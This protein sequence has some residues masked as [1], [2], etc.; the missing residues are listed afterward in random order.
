M[1][2]LAASEVA[3]SKA[4]TESTNSKSAT[5]WFRWESYLRQIDID[6]IFLSSFSREDRW[7]VLVGFC[8]A[9][10]DGRF[11]PGKRK[12]M[13]QGTIQDSLSAVAQAFRIHRGDDPRVDNQG[14]TALILLR[15][16]K[17]LKSDDPPPK[18][19]APATP[20]LIRLLA[21]SDESVPLDH[22]IGKL[23]CGSYFY[24]MRS[25]EYLKV[26]GPRK[27]KILLVEDIQF[28]VANREIHHSSPEIFDSDTVTLTFKD[29]KNGELMQRRTAWR[30]TDPI[31]SPVKAWASIVTRILSYQGCSKKTSVNT[32]LVNG[33]L[34]QITSA[35][36]VASIRAAA[37]TLGRNRLGYGPE[38][39]GTHSIRC[40]AA[41]AM[42]LGG[43]ATFVIMITGRWKSAAFMEYI[44]EQIAQFSEGVSQRMILRQNYFAIP[45]VDTDFLPKEVD[46]IY[47]T[48]TNIGRDAPRQFDEL[49]RLLL[50]SS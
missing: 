9:L 4:V 34:I 48:K 32:V 11:Q 19:Q 12:G 35:M 13:V 24:A 33:R 40:G 47:T 22:A 6:D 8:S 45:A 7:E 43:C 23:A 21:I 28:H 17:G 26:S 31:L 14:N 15:T 42:Y 3:R 30:T 16:L 20:E 25:C 27:T 18:K 10:R 29:Q 36:M 44:R 50:A 38:S 49:S 46:P 41:M 39:F 1:A 37:S 2:D 5:A